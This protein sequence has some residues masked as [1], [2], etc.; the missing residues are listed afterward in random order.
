V[1]RRQEFAL[2]AAANQALPKRCS[3]ILM[4]RKI[5]GLPQK[6]IA[7]QI[8][9]SAHTV[10]AQVG[11]GTTRLTTPLPREGPIIPDL[12]E[13]LGYITALTSSYY[14][15]DGPPVPPRAVARE[16]AAQD[17]VTV[18]WYF[19]LKSHVRT[20]PFHACQQAIGSPGH[21]P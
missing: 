12:L 19:E 8:V 17:L 2:L 4:L 9:I 15:L 11:I 6:E 1:S 3:Q 13:P 10:E 20:Q 14:H 18:R 21:A 5:Y 16:L 7:R